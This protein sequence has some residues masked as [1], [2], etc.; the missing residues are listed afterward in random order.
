MQKDF[1]VLCATM[2]QKDFSKI[3]EMNIESDIL[4]ANQSNSTWYAKKIISGNCA[5]MITTETRGLGNNRNILLVHA[6]AEICLLADDDVIYYVGY[7]DKILNAFKR[8]PDADMIIFNIDDNSENRKIKKITNEKKMRFWNK[9]PYASARI[10]FRL[11]SQRKYNIW[12]NNLL[13]TGSLYGSG[14]DTLFVNDFR[15]KGKVYLS[16]E[17][18]GY[19]DFSQSTWFSGYNEE[20]FFNQGA[21]VAGLKKIVKWVW[22]LYYAFSCPSE[23]VSVKEKLKLMYKG[24]C[25]YKNL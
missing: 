20:Y 13:G 4:Y 9:N 15:E 25:E 23:K 14:E 19:Q 17:V 18:L 16:T 24:Y 8:L 3:K 10:A 21:K 5:E 6:N 7:K 11:N 2:Y 12:F 22:F 1:Q